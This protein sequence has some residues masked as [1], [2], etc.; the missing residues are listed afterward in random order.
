MHLDGSCCCGAVRFSLE[1]DTPVPFLRCYCSICRKTAG[2]GGFAINIGGRAD[3]LVVEGE[4]AVTVYQATIDGRQ[5]PA[6]RR[7]CSRCG[8]P[9]WAWDPRWPDLVHP[10]AGAIDTPLPEA[11]ENIHIMLNSKP[12]WVRVDDGGSEERFDEYP[13]ESLEAWHLRHGLLDAEKS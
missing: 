2:A 6:E 4:D 7:F 9:L 3:S 12:V 1:A 13:S 8:S 5:S 10:F 11:P